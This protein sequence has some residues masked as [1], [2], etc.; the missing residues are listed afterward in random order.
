VHHGDLEP[1]TFS[2]SKD[3]TSSIKLAKRWRE[4]CDT[5]HAKCKGMISDKSNPSR[6]LSIRDGNLKLLCSK[7][8]PDNVSYAT[9]S[10][11][12]GT[13]ETFQLT[14]GNF[15]TLQESIEINDLCK[16]FQDAIGIA[17]QFGFDFLWIDSLC[18]IQNDELDWARESATMGKVYGNS[19][20]NI[21][22][23]GAADGTEGCFFNRPPLINNTYCIPLTVRDKPMIYQFSDRRPYERLV[24]WQPL[25]TRAWVVQ[26][27]IMARRNLHFTRSELFW[28]CKTKS[29]SESFPVEFP[30][31]FYYPVNGIPSYYEKATMPTWG[32][33][34]HMYSRANLTYARDKLVALS[35][36]AEVY[37][38]EARGKYLAGMW[39]T[40]L[41]IALC[42]Q[43][44]YQRKLCKRPSEYRAPTWSW[45][46]VD[47]EISR[48]TV[49]KLDARNIEFC[50]KIKDVMVANRGDDLF[51][52]IYD[53]VL[54]LRCT[55]LSGPVGAELPGPTACRRAVTFNLSDTELLCSWDCEE[56]SQNSGLHYFVPIVRGRRD[57]VGCVVGLILKNNGRDQHYESS[58]IWIAS[59]ND[60]Y[61]RV[62][63]F[64]T[65]GSK[66]Y[67]SIMEEIFSA[68]P[69]GRGEDIIEIA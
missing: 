47:G 53:G 49:N 30:R 20:L 69:E 21:A 51:G 56:Y 42:W 9:L 6:L 34:I 13:L 4:E 57:G 11:C 52:E 29:A 41:E 65:F 32:K 16:T 62:G 10:H 17:R 25:T 5:S 44:H 64:S 1:A 60:R 66:A 12:W 55:L 28:E 33:I 3:Y 38:S 19:A 67:D 54:K 45:A 26:E 18:I 39:R 14:K 31:H 36:I 24:E 58:E 61:R 59:V 35:G 43:L 46:S 40:G 63:L 48:E 23:T 37:Q 68:R 15:D 2:R 8:I 50:I 7:D 22:A 27:R